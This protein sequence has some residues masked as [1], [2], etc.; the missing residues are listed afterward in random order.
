MYPILMKASRGFA[1][2]GGA[3]AV[4][5]HS[6]YVSLGFKPTTQSTRFT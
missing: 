6:V 2:E 1:A 4:S 3:G 5:F